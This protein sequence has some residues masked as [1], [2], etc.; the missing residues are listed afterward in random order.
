MNKYKYKKYL[1][2][3]KLIIIFR[4]KKIEITYYYIIKTIILKYNI[5]GKFLKYV[6]YIRIKK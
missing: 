1:S 6:K 2:E 4:F 5:Y 3:L